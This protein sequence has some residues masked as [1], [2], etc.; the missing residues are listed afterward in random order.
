MD[1]DFAS[2]VPSLFIPRKWKSLGS[3][4]GLRMCV[5]CVHVAEVWMRVFKAFVFN[6]ERVHPSIKK[7]RLQHNEPVRLLFGGW[8]KNPLK[9]TETKEKSFCKTLFQLEMGLNKVQKQG[10]NEGTQEDVFLQMSGSLAFRVILLI[11]LNIILVT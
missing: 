8:L 1:K 10:R 4:L 7:V 9:R 2:F 3:R 6:A 11:V 5:V